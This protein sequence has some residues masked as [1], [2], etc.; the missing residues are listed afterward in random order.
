M[1]SFFISWVAT[2]F[3]G[4]SL[5]GIPLGLTEAELESG[6][7]TYTVDD[8]KT[9]YRF[10]EGPV[11]K[12]TKYAGGAGESGY[13]FDLYED[14]VINLNKVGVPALSIQI[15]CDKVCAIKVYDFS[16]P[17]EA[18]SAFVYKGELSSNIGLGSILA[19]LTPFTS[20]EFDRA[21]AWFVTDEHFGFIEISG[22]GVPLEEE[23]RQLITAICVI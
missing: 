20:L 1:N 4:V 9:L 21:E 13:V 6:L 8:N 2:I 18:A 23:P 12:L 3:P 19:G 22:W 16:F 5:A 17:G 10:E 7:A 14:S 11:L 15:E